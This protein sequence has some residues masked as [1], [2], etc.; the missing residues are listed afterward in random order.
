M[1]S[2][3]PSDSYNVSLPLFSGFLELNLMLGCG[4]RI[5]S[6]Q[7]L[8]DAPGDN[9]VSYHSISIAEYH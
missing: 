4:S 8:D 9:L 7:L 6:H 2:L 1:W 5:Y 3:D